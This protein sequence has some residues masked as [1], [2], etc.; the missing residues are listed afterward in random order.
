M[1]CKRGGEYIGEISKRL[2]VRLNK[3]KYNINKGIFDR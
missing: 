2:D 3:Y 1:P